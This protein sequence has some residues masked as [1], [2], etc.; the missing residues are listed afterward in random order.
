MYGDKIV[1]KAADLPGN[2]TEKESVLA[3]QL[4]ISFRETN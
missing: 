1:V 4:T 2:L 3:T